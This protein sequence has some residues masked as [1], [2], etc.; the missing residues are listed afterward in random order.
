MDKQ[1]HTVKTAQVSSAVSIISHEMPRKARPPGPEGA[2]EEGLSSE[3]RELVFLKEASAFISL[4]T[5]K[6]EPNKFFNPI[7]VDQCPP[8][9]QVHGWTTWLLYATWIR[10]RFVI[11]GKQVAQAEIA[12]PWL[13]PMHS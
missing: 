13:G 7:M 6:S 9:V 3:R 2:V 12:F 5:F 1:P 10:T 8:S 11:Q 4:S